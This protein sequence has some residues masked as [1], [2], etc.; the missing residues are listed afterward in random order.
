MIDKNLP[1]DA[2][3]LNDPAL[4][5]DIPCESDCHCD[6]CQEKYEEGV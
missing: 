3:G 2:Q 4:R 1:L 6:D 5:L